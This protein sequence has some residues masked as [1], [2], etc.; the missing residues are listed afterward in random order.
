MSHPADEAAYFARVAF[1]ETTGITLEDPMDLMDPLQRF[2]GLFNRQ[3][4]D[5]LC[6]DAVRL[7]HNKQPRVLPLGVGSGDY[8][9]LPALLCGSAMLIHAS[10]DLAPGQAEQAVEWVVDHTPW[11][12]A[13]LLKVAFLIKH[14]RATPLP[15]PAIAALTAWDNEG[16]DLPVSVLF[17][18][19]AAALVVQAESGAPLTAHAPAREPVDGTEYLRRYMLAAL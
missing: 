19:L 17:V 8:Y 16:R 7:A 11:D 13:L 18:G 2:D 3:V 9:T 6:A 5:G 15:V 4:M 1:C 14:P 12:E 10:V